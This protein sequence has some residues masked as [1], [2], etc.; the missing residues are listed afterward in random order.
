MA[1]ENAT[2]IDVARRAG[3]SQS[4]V[5]RVFTPGASAS[6]QT[7]E[8]VRKAA[9]EL[10]YRPNSLAR[11]MVS[12]KSRIIGLVVAYL[13]NQFYPEALEKLSNELQERGYHVLVFLA[14]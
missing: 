12:G 14:A 13:Q 8:K 10:G 11:A 4:A 1:R 3:V 6:R 2:S 9:N 5:S 7:V